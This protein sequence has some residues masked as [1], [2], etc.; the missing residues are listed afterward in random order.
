L[1][2]ALASRWHLPRWSPSRRARTTGG[3]IE[4]GAVHLLKPQTYM[5]DSGAALR[6]LRAATPDDTIADLLVLVD[7]FA[8]EAGTFRLRASGSAGGHNGLTSVEAEVGTRHYARLRIGIGPRPEGMDQAEFV[9]GV[10]PP[11][12][13]KR[14]EEL[15][16]L[17]TEAVECWAAE[18][19][20]RAMAGYNR[21]K[22]LEP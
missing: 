7:D 13:R 18:G 4:A 9:L 21:R 8:L 1:A 22:R 16:P 20:E 15:Y 5:N 3:R 11:D 6:G 2:D 10:M 17:M 12:E 19:I 14:I